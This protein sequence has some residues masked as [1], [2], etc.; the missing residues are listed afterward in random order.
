MCRSGTTLNSLILQYF[1]DTG[2][3]RKRI[4]VGICSFYG[5]LRH[6]WI[7]TETEWHYS[8]WQLYM[9]QNLVSIVGNTTFHRIRFCIVRWKIGDYYTGVHCVFTKL[10]GTREVLA[11][12]TATAKTGGTK[13]SFFSTVFLCMTGKSPPEPAGKQLDEISSPVFICFPVEYWNQLLWTE[14]K[15]FWDLCSYMQ[16]FRFV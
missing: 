11:Y 3:G 13:R 15:R 7:F 9:K 12:V 14:Q 4:Q 1:W 5:A 2:C 10:F 6:A 16:E 8:L